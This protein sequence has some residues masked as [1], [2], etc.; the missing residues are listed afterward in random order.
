MMKQEARIIERFRIVEMAQQESVSVAARHFACSRTTIYHLLE[1]YEQGGLLALANQPRGPGEPIPEEAVESVV[2]LKTVAPH[3]TSAKVQRLLQ[4]RH[5]ILLSRQSVW[6]ILSARGLARIQDP[7]PLQRFE[8]PL[9]NQLWQMDL[10][11]D[12][13]F[14]FGKAHLLLLLD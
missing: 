11:E 13:V 10:K 3:R 4:E 2:A 8:R 5:G 7:E 1:R 12:V 6:R 9:P 14:S